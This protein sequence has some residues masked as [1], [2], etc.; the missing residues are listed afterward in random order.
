MKIVI[1]V[2]AKSLSSNDQLALSEWKGLFLR[3]RAQK[4]V[5][6]LLSGD[7]AA[8]L[9]MGILDADFDLSPHIN[10]FLQRAIQLFLYSIYCGRELIPS[11]LKNRLISLILFAPTWITRAMRTR[12][13]CAITFPRRPPISR[14]GG[15]TIIVAV[16]WF[17]ALL[18]AQSLCSERNDTWLLHWAKFGLV[19]T[20]V[21]V[22]GL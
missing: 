6:S 5:I 7:K 21:S 19:L 16:E 13:F 10:L 12:A 4:R 15:V 1:K 8:P 17:S 3:K 2:V 14:A 11:C 9:C 18:K 20:Q 22:L